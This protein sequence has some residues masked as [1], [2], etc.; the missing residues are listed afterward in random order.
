MTMAKIEADDDDEEEVDE[1][2]L[3]SYTTIVNSGLLNRYGCSYS[4]HDLFFCQSLNL[5]RW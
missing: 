5:S 4:T 2:R 3:Q 1:E